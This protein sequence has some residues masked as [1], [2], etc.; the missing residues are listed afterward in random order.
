M[1][2]ECTRCQVVEANAGPCPRCGTQ[3]RYSLLGEMK[4]Q[5]PKTKTTQLKQAAPI[6]KTTLMDRVIQV[7]TVVGWMLSLLMMIELGGS[8]MLNQ[9]KAELG[10]DFEFSP[11]LMQYA[12]IAAASI[13]LFFGSLIGCWRVHLGQLIGAGSGVIAGGLIPC[14]QLLLSRNPGFLDWAATPMLG[15]LLGFFGGI[16]TAKKYVEPAEPEL[17]EEENEGEKIVAKTREFA[18]DP[19]AWVKQLGW[20]WVTSII[21]MSI[22]NYVLVMI[23]M[24]AGRNA[25]QMVQTTLAKVFMNCLQMF[26]LSFVAGCYTKRGLMQGFVAGLTYIFLVKSIG[27]QYT[28]DEFFL[29]CTIGLAISA[30]AGKLGRLVC[31]PPKIYYNGDGLIRDEF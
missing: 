23:L 9:L 20:G 27:F 5:K 6:I 3:M 1:A 21:I 18:E 16:V 13:A 10:N 28:E 30:G 2:F 25:I 7:I 8:A 31:G 11:M 19:N 24:S 15:L 22:I 26:I 14:I 4:L 29:I 12:P 17:V